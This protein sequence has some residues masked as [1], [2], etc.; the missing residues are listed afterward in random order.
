MFFDTHIHTFFSG[1]GQQ[2]MTDACETAIK[3]GL[4]GICFT[5]HI[6]IDFPGFASDYFM[7]E[8]DDYEESYKECVERYKDSGLT[9][10]KGVEVGI[11]PHVMDE[12]FALIKDQRV[13]ELIGSFHIVNG[14]DPC[15]SVFFRDRAK[16]TVYKEYLNCIID[17]LPYLK[18]FDILGHFDYPMRYATYPEKTLLLKDYP[19][20]ISYIL[21]FMV[22]NG[23]CLEINTRSY[24]RVALD[25]EILKKYKELGGIMVS[26]GS[27]SHISSDIGLDFNKYSKIVKDAGF[28]YLTHF[29]KRKPVLE[30]IL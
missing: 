22:R 28:T 1:D 4:S 27:D 5:D 25:I 29:V 2:S 7:I 10:L 8:F 20:E 16:E 24:R 15:E 17:S 3:Y 30:K 19:E 23:I 14:K 21:D 18:E 13:D 11:Q 26:L 9:I 12:T 6:D